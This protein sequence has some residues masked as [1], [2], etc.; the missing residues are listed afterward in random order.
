[1]V[2]SW[3][4]MERAKLRLD[5]R[6]AATQLPRFS[7]ALNYHSDLGR[8]TCHRYRLLSPGTRPRWS[9]DRSNPRGFSVFF[10]LS[11]PPPTSTKIVR[12]P[13]AIVT[14]KPHHL[15]IRR[16]QT[17]GTYVRII[18]TVTVSLILQIHCFLLICGKL[19]ANSIL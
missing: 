5:R 17:A 7:F 14:I 6:A 18:T 13:R 12:T 15:N 3:P 4:V 9:V 16:S 1:M 2:F 8:F 10:F 19:C 11:P